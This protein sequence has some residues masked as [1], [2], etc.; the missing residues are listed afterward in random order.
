[1]DDSSTIP[2]SI[3]DRCP[4][5]DNAVEIAT[6][7]GGADCPRCGQYLW[8]V[9]R[10]EGDV[11]VLSF[12]PGLAPGAEYLGHVGE[13]LSAVGDSER[14]ILE[15]TNLEFMTSA[16]LGMLVDLHTRVRLTGVTIKVCGLSREVTNVLRTTKSDG[17]FDIH[18]SVRSAIKS[19]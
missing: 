2:A 8:F 18:S 5:C 13:L 12:V 4:S 19:F 9:K 16:F 6:L 15:F 1:M 7:S 14:L 11:V 10:T 3:P 17:L